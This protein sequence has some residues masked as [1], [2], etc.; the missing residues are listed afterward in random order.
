MFYSIRS[1]LMISFLGVSLLVGAVSLIVGGQLIYD[2]V[3][4][5]V[6]NRVRQDL[7]V[8]RLL[9]DKKGEDIRK[10]LETFSMGNDVESSLFMEEESPIKERLE[11]VADRLGLDFAGIVRPD[12]SVICRVGS[13]PAPGNTPP[14]ENSAVI[15]ALK[16][17]KPVA[18]TILLEASALRAESP[19]LVRR[20][21][22]E[23]TPP[24]KSAFPAAEGETAGLGIAAAV[25]VMHS[26][27]VKGVVYGGILINRETTIVDT[28][29]ETVF[30][31]EEYQGRS[32]GTATIFLKDFRVATTV[33]RQ[34]GERAVGTVAS[35]EVVRRVLEDGE[36]WID[37]AI[38]VDD[39]YIT[40]YEPIL[41][42]FGQRVGMLYVGILEAQYADVR[43]T[44]LM[45]FTGITLAGVG[46]A[47]LVGWLLS[48]RIVRPIN[49]LIQASV[50][51]SEGNLSPDIGP[52]SKSDFGVL[53]KKFQEMMTALQQREERQ[54]EESETR[55]IQSQKQASVG[56]LAAG[57]A[58]E[59]NNP[60]TAVLTYTHLTLR[61]NDL[62]ETVRADLENVSIQTERVR[63][64]V[65]GLLDF[66]RQTRP[67]T[68]T[69][70]LN[71]LVEDCVRLMENQALVRGVSLE[72]SGK[73]DLPEVTVDRNQIQSV[74][75]NMMINALDAT[76]ADGSI[77]V[78][79]DMSLSES[80]GVEISV[81]DT[82]CG[83]A[84][85]DME[86]LFDPFFT[87]KEVGKGTG[88]GLSVSAGIIERHGGSIT[89][90]STV[91]A[92]SIFTVWLPVQNN[93]SM[94]PAPAGKWEQ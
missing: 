38:V 26:G 74:I 94:T 10:A 14:T 31:N 40:A 12:R 42:I 18:G 81:A 4:S 33:R 71:E 65:K 29:A 48:D 22:M 68:E 85:T 69:I 91:G 51:V 73:A 43:R 17:K 62:P 25:P 2:S 13:H 19:D 49:R 77:T 92:G 35:E 61:R 21:R 16:Q 32:V 36:K 56:R 54:K 7:N 44:A 8:A 34:D 64:I 53:Q 47:L 6:S 55:L 63:K 41:D 11:Q 50:N 87:T 20:A 28:I 60:L 23:T 52:V 67:E 72:F 82:G 27:T 58:H 30:Q 46:V 80:P 66:A 57:V 1:K 86:R 83:I 78:S 3:V 90:R 88:L 15:A 70:H 59:I 89:V 5:E 76:Q 39:W 24:V 75:I 93:A 45:V 9:Y 79:T 84:A 37:R